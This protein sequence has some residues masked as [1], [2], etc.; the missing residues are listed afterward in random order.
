VRLT[1]AVTLIGRST[2]CDLQIKRED[3]SKRHCRILID[4]RQA[5]VEDLSSTAGTS[6][7]DE[8]VIHRQ[9]LAT[10]DRLQIAKY[11]FRVTLDLNP[12]D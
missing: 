9:S 11:S 2:E 8:P 1:K 7:N 12:Q 6:V 3:V 4:G 5:E 10:G